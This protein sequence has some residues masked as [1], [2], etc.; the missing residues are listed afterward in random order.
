M[1]IELKDLPSIVSL[2]EAMDKHP[3]GAFVLA[4][5]VCITCMA[6]VILASFY[7]YLRLHSR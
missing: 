2:V 1:N 4:L 7:F 3:F 5:I 6:A